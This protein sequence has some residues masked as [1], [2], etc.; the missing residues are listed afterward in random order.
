MKAIPDYRNNHYVPVWYQKR[1]IPTDSTDCELFYLDLQ[2][3]SFRTPNGIIIAKKALKRQG[4]RHCFKQLDLYTQEFAGKRFIEIERQ[5]FGQIDRTGNRAVE[6]ATNFSHTNWKPQ[7]LIQLVNYL[8]A[9]KLRTPKGLSWLAWQMRSQRIPTLEALQIYISM[10]TAIWVESIWQ[11]ADADLSD[12]KFIISDHPVTSYN[13]ALG[14]NS[15]ACL[16]HRDPDIRQ[17]GSHT[18]FPLSRD[19]ILI[20]TNLSWVLNPYQNPKSFRPNPN[21]FRDAMLN[22]LSIQTD[23][24]MNETEVREVNFIIKS[25]AGRYVA[26]G[27]EEWLYP[28]EFVSKSDWS[29]YGHGYLLMPDPRCVSRSGPVY[30]GYKD[31]GTDAFDP[32]GRRPWQSGF[33]HGDQTENWRNF[34][35][36]KGEFARLHGPVRRG[37]NNELG[38]VCKDVDEPW[39]HEYHLSL[40]KRNAEPRRHRRYR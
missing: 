11:I 14:P 24:H 22:V 19:K 9:Q 12:T 20:F 13:R 4:P 25:R 15:D 17:H 26:G 34:D 32:Y 31:G 16:G 5:F 1:F 28:E 10:F 30:I 7:Q 18:I 2:P 3:G 8:S 40:E 27:K 35:R 29:K 23:R 39:F 21:L 33:P 36:F 37:R 6:A 38:G